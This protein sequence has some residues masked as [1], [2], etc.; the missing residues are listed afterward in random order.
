MLMR[1]HSLIV[2]FRFG[3]YLINFYFFL[4]VLKI[5]N[6]IDL[7]KIYIIEDKNNKKKKSRKM[8]IDRLHRQRHTYDLK[9]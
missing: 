9:L 5:N 1:I 4:I 7:L 6:L 2:C 8:S 3:I